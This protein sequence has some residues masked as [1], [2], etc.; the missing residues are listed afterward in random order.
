MS[1][2][3]DEDFEEEIIK[4]ETEKEK[5]QREDK[6]FFDNCKDCNGITMKEQRAID[7]KNR[8][9]GTNVREGI[10]MDRKK[11]EEYFRTSRTSQDDWSVL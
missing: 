7:L 10:E 11:R 1:N 4:E 8:T 9:D 3:G 2:F 5:S 6:E